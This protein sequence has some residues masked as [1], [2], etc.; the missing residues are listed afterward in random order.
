MTA[1]VKA[2]GPKP[3]LERTRTYHY[4]EP[5]PAGL[6]DHRLKWRVEPLERPKKVRA[7][8]TVKPK[9]QP[10]PKNPTAEK[11]KRH[12]WTVSEREDII[13][14]RESGEDWAT[15]ADDYSTTIESIKSA[16][17]RGIGTK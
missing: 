2:V 13:Q 9:P 17:R 16:Y 12:R 7:K 14:R 6:D 4:I 10:K 1:T 8:A 11:S 15:I 3:L 5:M